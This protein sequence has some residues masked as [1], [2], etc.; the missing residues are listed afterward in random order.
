M[1][2]QN[3][4]EL[5]KQ[6]N[7]KAIA[8]LVTY[9]LQPQHITAQAARKDSCLQIMLEA[10]QVPDQQTMIP[11]VRR[12][13]TR[14]GVEHIQKVKVFGRQIGEDFPAWSQEFDLEVQAK[15]ENSQNNQLLTTPKSTIGAESP[16]K[17]L[18]NE[19]VN[20]LGKGINAFA[21][22][23][24][25]AN[26][27]EQY[28]NFINNNG[29]IFP[30]NIP[31]FAQGV[32]KSTYEKSIRNLAKKLV[33]FIDQYEELVDVVFVRHKKINSY[34]VVTNKR[35]LCVLH[36][37]L[38]IVERGAALDK[39]VWSSKK[40]DINF[41]EVKK[42]IVANNGLTLC[43]KSGDPELDPELKLYFV[44]S[45]IYDS[46]TQLNKILLPFVTV[47]TVD[48]IPVDQDEASARSS[49]SLGCGCLLLLLCLAFFGLSSLFKQPQPDPVQAPV[50]NSPPQ[51]EDLSPSSSLCPC[52][53]G[54]VY[55]TDSQWA[56]MSGSE[57]GEFKRQVRA[58]TGKCTIVVAD[59]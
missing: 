26:L 23:L 52:D 35:C 5:A 19:G 58:S 9:H 3:I 53:S 22:S 10:A 2:Q 4:L 30:K 49:D 51:V 8:A 44:H 59:P 48:S 57:R 56:V 46:S 18:I 39:L 40:F 55:V 6:G 36:M 31:G 16:Y 34:L 27:E 33:F 37:P 41:K 13:I 54:C 15:S 7:A 21:N 42:I 17:H 47:E 43:H 50:T 20:L 11:F 29:H 28:A 1:A 12:V 32:H 25:K 38:A 45:N 14:L 24:E